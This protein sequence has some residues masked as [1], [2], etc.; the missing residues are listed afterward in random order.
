MNGFWEG[1]LGRNRLK[2]TPLW[3]LFWLVLTGPAAALEIRVGLNQGVSELTVGSSTPAEVLN[4]SGQVLG[5]IPQLKGITAT[6][7]VGGVSVAGKKSWQI[8]LKPKENGFIYAGGHWYRGEV[9]L[10][11]ESSGMTVVNQLDMED[12][13]ASVIGKEMYNTWPAEALKAQAVA[14]RSYAVFQKQRPKYQR[15][16]VLS[17]TTSQVYA[18]LEAETVST[19][20]AVKATTGKVLTYEGKV[21]EAVFHSASGGHTESSENVWQKAVPY[22]RGVT[23]FDQSAPSFQWTLSLTAA[24]MRQR[25]P[26]IGD[27]ISLTPVRTSPTGRVLALKI[28]GSR[29]S[30]LIKGT[31]ARSELG[32]KSTLFTVQPEF[33]LVAGKAGS[34]PIRFLISGRGHGHGLGLSQWGAY[35]LAQQNKSYEEILMH[36]FQGTSL[37]TVY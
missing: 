18:G 26:G 37:K 10:I 22:L 28:T 27:I 35:G 5:E 32:L 25:I 7:T 24:Q 6:T 14:S 16:D 31:E 8:I 23:D 17:T 33:G 1:R 19:Q 13:L 15:F 11:R 36:Y 9:S 21:I 12:Y 34:K 20:E 30:R 2:V 4:G 3:L 29:G